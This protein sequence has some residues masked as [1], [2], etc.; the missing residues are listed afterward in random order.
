MIESWASSSYF[1]IS[2]FLMTF[3]K[4]TVMLILPYLI[5]NS[6][7]SAYLTSQQP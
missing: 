6:Y 7:T 1:L 5:A 3:I 2:T 4:L